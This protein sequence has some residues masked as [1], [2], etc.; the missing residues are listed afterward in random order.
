MLQRVEAGFD[1]LVMNRNGYR[2]SVNKQKFVGH[3]TSEV[4]EKIDANLVIIG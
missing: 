4:L 1:W 3:N 2:G